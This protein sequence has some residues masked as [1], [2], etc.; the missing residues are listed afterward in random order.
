MEADSSATANSTHRLNAIIFLCFVA[1]FFAYQWGKKRAES[2]SFAMGRLEPMVARI[3][4]IVTFEW[5]SVTFRVKI[6]LGGK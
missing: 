3:V 5:F 6:L 1:G 2:S 4:T